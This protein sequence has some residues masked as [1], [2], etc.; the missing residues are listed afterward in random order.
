MHHVLS[1][2]EPFAHNDVTS[3]TSQ[4]HTHTH[5]MAV[6]MLWRGTPSCPLFK[7]MKRALTLHSKQFRRGM[8]ARAGSN[9]SFRS[10]S[11]MSGGGAG[12]ARTSRRSKHTVFHTVDDYA[13]GAVPHKFSLPGVNSPKHS[14]SEGDLLT[15]QNESVT[16]QGEFTSLATTQW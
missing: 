6:S 16:S 12:A 14:A 9:R 5:T 4:A 11:G 7:A 3:P 2:N 15:F 10:T 13:A 1:A 8:Y